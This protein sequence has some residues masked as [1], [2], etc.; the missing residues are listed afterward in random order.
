M[1]IYNNIIPHSPR[2]QFH[3]SECDGPLII[4]AK[5]NM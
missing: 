5:K 2:A 3:A 4:Y 1:Q